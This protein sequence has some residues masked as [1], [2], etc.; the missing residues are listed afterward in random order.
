M[1]MGSNVIRKHWESIWFSSW[2]HL[3]CPEDPGLLVIVLKANQEAKP[4]L[5]VTVFPCLQGHRKDHSLGLCV[6][7]PKCM[8]GSWRSLSSHL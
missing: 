1:E 5:D 8:T 2:E 3:A 6:T 7:V 4:S